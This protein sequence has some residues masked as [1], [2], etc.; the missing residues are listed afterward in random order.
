MEQILKVLVGSRAHGL[1]TDESDVDYRGVF[2]QPTEAVLSM[3][4]HMKQTSWVEGDR[5]KETGRKQDDTAWEIG[6]F[7]HMATKCNPT[8]LEVFAAPIIEATEEGRTL[9]SLFPYVW[10]PEAVMNSFIGYGRNQQKKMLADEE[11]PKW[12]KF[13]A[14]WLRVLCQAERLLCHGVMMLDVQKHEEYQ[15]MLMFR[16]KLATMGQVVDKCR[17]WEARVRKARKDATT[18]QRQE[19]DLKKVDRFLLDVRAAHFA[20]SPSTPRNELQTEGA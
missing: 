9:Q 3:L 1:A 8:V 6:H 12:P 15:T 18:A 10:E 7:L 16:N 13:A 5:E 17:Q 4:G 2:V 19:P 11:F 14:T 20:C